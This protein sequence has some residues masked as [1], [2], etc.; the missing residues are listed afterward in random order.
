MRLFGYK[1]SLNNYIK[2]K[3]KQNRSLR[4]FSNSPEL[5]VF[6]LFS[7]LFF[8]L[9]I[10]LFFVQIIHHKKYDDVLNS[11]HVSQSLL[12]A[13][14]GA[15]YAYDKSENEVKL[16]ENISMYNVFVDPKFIGDKE[17]FIELF[18]PVVYKHL[19][20]IQG[21]E[22]LEK[23]DCIENLEIFATKDLLPKAPEFFYMGSGIVSDGYYTYDWTGYNQ[24]RQEIIDNFSTGVAENLIKNGLDKRIEIGI[25]DLNYIGFFSNKS[26]LEELKDLDLDYVVVKYDNYV[27]IDPDEISNVS[28]ESIPLINL[29]KKYSY[30]RSYTNFEKN[31]YEQENRY[32]K[33]LSNANPVVAQMVKN[34]KLEYYQERT[35]DNVPILHGLGLESYV[36]RYYPYGS[37]LSNVLGY[38]DKN[39]EAYYGIEQYFDDILRGKDGKIIGRASA[40]IG[41]VGANEFEIEDVVD[42]DDV[43]LTVDIGI[44][45]E[46][47]SIAKKRQQSLNSDSVSV[48]VYDPQNGHVKASVNYPSFN[49]NNYNDAYTLTPLLVEDSY[50]VDNETYIDIP[51]YIKTGGETRLATTYERVDT[52]IKKYVTK[53]LYGSQVFVDK[54]ISMAYEPGSIFKIFTVGVG[55]DTDEISF[56][57]FYNDPGQV[58]VGPYT[59]KN[60][61][62]K[63]CMGEHSFMNALVFSCNIGMVRIVQAVGK[64]NFYNYLS[65]LNFGQLTNIEL[66]GEDPG[67]LESV[68]TVSLAR[69][70]N[71][72]FGQG[73]LAT[74]IQIAAAYGSLVNGGYYIKP[75]ILAGIRDNQTNRYYPNKTEVLRQIFRPETA[76]EIRE[77]LFSVMEKNPDYT[78]DIKV[79]GYD[80]G[81]KSGTSQISFKGK[82]QE[83]LGWTN[84]SFVGLITKDDPRYV[85]VIQVRRPRAS[86]WG[87]QT[88][89]R[90]FSDVAK[91]LIGYSLIE[92]TN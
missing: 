80:L 41:N 65:K 16:T 25:K 57:D 89:G 8:I 75:T 38:V 53:N 35:K 67:S 79:E 64:N 54:N 20:E 26:F 45:N 21:M 50:V 17:R 77:G 90:V 39:D 27:Y 69:Y 37:F 87:A 11:Q 31:F 74:P 51:V 18:T 78:N 4:D 12:K 84:G 42:G 2:K 48:L 52:E 33:L 82:Y 24:Q 46:I 62:N 15:V 23:I 19:C 14:R 70:L 63:H 71:N 10:R 58:K 30:F 1:I 72:S 61:D 60:A 68:S 73:L 91:F 47:E 28:R 29:L 88:A 59:I 86:Y 76:D 43:Y 56:Y 85:V 34:L 81:G 7:F 44:Q 6:F 9:F 49:P 13:D 55:L 22:V 66:A 3:I 83:G 92:R 32:V 36:N 5:I 40:W